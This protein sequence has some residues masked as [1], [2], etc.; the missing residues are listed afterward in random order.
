MIMLEDFQTLRT[1][2]ADRLKISTSLTK[3]GLTDFNDKNFIELIRLDDGE[4]K[5]YKIQLNIH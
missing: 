5:N 4:L 1:P 2:G 3:K